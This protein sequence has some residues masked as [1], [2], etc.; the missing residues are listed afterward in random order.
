MGR[1]GKRQHPALVAAVI[2][3]LVAVVSLAVASR[4][5]APTRVVVSS[6]SSGDGTSTSATGGNAAETSTSVET[7]TTPAPIETTT[8]ST[9]TSTT[10]PSIGS[11]PT[12]RPTTNTLALDGTYFG[13]EHFAV[14]TGRCA[15]LDHHIAG[16]FKPSDATTW[17]FRQDYCGTLHGDLWSAVGTFALTAPDGATITG[18]VTEKNIKVPSPGV[19]YTLD[20]TGGTQRFA[21]ATGTCRLDNH[22]REIEFGLQEDYGSF[23][24]S[25]QV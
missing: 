21:A 2:V 14:N 12:S 19:P 3:G 13:V 25:I 11:T 7:S 10:A 18:T 8:T 22:L 4:A 15:F 1:S 23:T 5:D 20:I 24:C 17:G 9:T 16:T 6:P